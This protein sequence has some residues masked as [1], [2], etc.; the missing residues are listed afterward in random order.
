MNANN[1]N[2]I[3]NDR[4]IL[5][6]AGMAVAKCAF[7]IFVNA[8]MPLLALFILLNLLLILVASLLYGKYQMLLV[9]A[10]NILLEQSAII[11]F[12]AYALIHKD[13]YQL[14]NKQKACLGIAV[15]SC[16]FDGL[17]L[18]YLKMLYLRMKRPR[19]N[20]EYNAI[21]DA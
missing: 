20:D 6:I 16:L 13:S 17:V 21:G 14:D 15:V 4:L 1:A 7:A 11:V 5:T 12:L 3:S 19:R 18:Y 9:G 2:R 8:L 10:I